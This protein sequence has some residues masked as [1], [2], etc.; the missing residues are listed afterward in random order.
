MVDRDLRSLLDVYKASVYNKDV[1][2]LLS[3]YDN[4]IRAFD[5]W[6]VWLYDSFDEW[7]QMNEKWLNSL[8]QDR[9]V[10]EFDDVKIDSDGDNGFASAVMTFSGVS[11]S[12]AVLRSM[13]TRLTW[14]A[15]RH[16]SGWKIVHQHTSVPIDGGTTRAILKRA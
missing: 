16:P 10:V 13:E 12:G 14:I 5:T 15:R 11:D 3:L 4:D 6:G 7:R 8:D 9:V 1:V 2:S